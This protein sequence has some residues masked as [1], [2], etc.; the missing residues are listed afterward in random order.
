ME[1][2]G[3]V[4]HEASGREVSYSRIAC[5]SLYTRNQFQIQGSASFCGSESPPLHGPVC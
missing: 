2:G 1:Q 3:R 4:L 5:H